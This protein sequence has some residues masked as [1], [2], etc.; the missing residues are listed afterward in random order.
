MQITYQP[1]LARIF[2]AV[3][4][5]NVTQTAPPND[6]FGKAAALGALVAVAVIVLPGMLSNS[7]HDNSV[8][9]G[10]STA[11][12]KDKAPFDAAKVPPGG[13]V[14]IGAYGGVPYTYNSDVKFKKTDVTDLTVKDVAWDGK[15]FKA[16]IYYGI[17]VARWSDVSPIGAM[18]DFTHGKVYSQRE[19][20]VDLEGKREG[21][22]LSPKAKIKEIFHHF[23]FTHGHNMLTLNGLYRLPRPHARLS[24]YVGAGFGIALPHSEV[25]FK[26]SSVRTYEYQY[27]GPVFQ[28]LIGMEFRI[29]RL[30]YFFEYK[31]TAASYEVP[32]TKRDGGYLFGDLYRQ[33]KRWW[34]GKAPKNGFAYTTLIS[35]QMIGGMGV[36]ISRAPAAP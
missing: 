12:A 27:T 7:E 26:G 10:A 9:N 8:T 19:Q 18:V 25:Q 32:L 11:S 28:F 5:Q 15:P 36:R 24:P 16:P 2:S 13:E 17:R 23:E 29:P 34:S 22:T 4:W 3:S 20:V 21:K 35:H 6:R 14:F 30:S 31:F 33:F 1:A